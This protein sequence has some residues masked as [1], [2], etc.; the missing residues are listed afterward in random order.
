MVTFLIF[1]HGLQVSL[2]S[3]SE[4]QFEIA[5]IFWEYENESGL[6]KQAISPVFGGIK[7]ETLGKNCQVETIMNHFIPLPPL[8]SVLFKIFI[9]IVK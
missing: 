2:C 7:K 6:S 5:L 9:T 1:K 4:S 3:N 8:V